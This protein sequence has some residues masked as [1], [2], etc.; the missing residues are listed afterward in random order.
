MKSL[1]KY[2]IF[3]VLFLSMLWVLAASLQACGE[4]EFRAC[5][6][7]QD[8]AISTKTKYCL[9]GVCSDKQ[10]ISGDEGVCYVGPKATAN[11][12]ICRTGRK[13]CLKEGVWSACL[14]QV[15]PR[16]EICDRVDND[17][18]G[19]VD[20]GIDCTCEPGTR[21][22]CYAGPDGTEAK[23]EC[24]YG[25][26]FCLPDNKWG[27]CLDQS[28]PSTE[29]CDKK[30]NDCNGQ[31][32]DGISCD[33]EAG[34][35]RSCYSSKGGCIEQADGSY[36]CEGSCAVGKQ[37]C[38]TDRIWGECV[39]QVTPVEESCDGQDNDCNGLID[40]NVAG[41]GNP[42]S[43]PTAKGIC[44]RGS[45]QCVDGKLS[46]VSLQKPVDEICGNGLD[47][48]CDGQIDETPPCGC[49]SGQSQTCYTETAG[50]KEGADGKWTCQGSCRTGMQFCLDTQV[51]S[52]CLSVQLPSTEV[53]DGIDNDCDGKTDEGLQRSCFGGPQQAVG[54]GECKQGTQTCKAGV[55][56]GCEGEVVPL[57]ETCNGK[58][59]NCDGQVDEICPCQAGQTQACGSTE[60]ECK[61][62]SQ[63][64]SQSGQWGPCQGQ[65]APAQE[66][67]D[68]KDNDCNGKIDDGALG[69]G[70]DC[71]TGQAG[72]CS[73]GK[74]QCQGGKVVCAG[75]SPVTELC[76]E[77][78]NDCDGKID[79]DWSKKGE[80]CNVGQG[81]CERTGT[82]VCRADL[83]DTQCN[84]VPGVPALDICDGKDNDCDGSVDEGCGGCMS[85][86][87]QICGSMVGLCRQGSQTCDQRGLWGPCVGE[88]A[89]QNEICDD[90]DNDCDGKVDENWPSKGFS[91]D[92]G[93]GA[94][95]QTGQVVC[96]TNKSGVLCDAV[97]NPP[98]TEICDGI[99][100]DCDGQIDG[101]T[102]SCEFPAVSIGCVLGAGG[103]W[104]CKG[105][106]RTGEQTCA[107][108][109]WGACSGSVLP[110]NEI[111]GN[112]ID[113]DCNGKVDDCDVAT[114]NLPVFTGPMNVV[115]DLAFSPNHTTIASAHSN[116]SVR[117][118]QTNSGAQLGVLT[119]HTNDVTSVVFLDDSTVI[120]ASKDMTIRY[121]NVIQNKLLSTISVHTGEINDLEIT[122]DKKVLASTSK[123]KTIRLWNAVDGMP[124]RTINVSDEPTRIT[125]AP[126][127]QTLAAVTKQKVLQIWRVSDGMLLQTISTTDDGVDV[128]YRPDGRVI[129]TALVNKEMS[130]WSPLSSTGP[131]QK[132][133][134]ANDAIIS[135]RYSPDGWLAAGLANGEIRIWTPSG[136]LHRTLS[137]HTT[138][139]RTVAW[140]SDSAWLAGTD[141]FGKII[142][143]Y[144]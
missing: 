7:D 37:S 2:M 73:S 74:S 96:N 82:I 44:Q 136:T 23:G 128:G 86:H 125:F 79:E 69:L 45:E 50:C 113:D 123:D 18:D 66:I 47:D 71:S 19:R 130:F 124:L 24:R 8:C 10:C 100:N 137:L 41:A 134:T 60:G 14:E 46:C 59:D 1:P 114:S 38:G 39:A 51:W 30:D 34:S 53:C 99:D 80:T 65:V 12:G 120:S 9:G 52:A 35:T 84:A 107:A 97:A 106:C 115:W 135:L 118:W 91:C 36:R 129:T 68:G 142:V 57:P 32:D 103:V 85:G 15:L 143:W 109:Q 144:R 105:T 131:L 90:Q 133:Y 22:K 72:A 17:C 127:G 5:S 119:G 43:H 89:P 64:C 108:G 116:K 117:L 3:R 29:I 87:T 126:D 112:G 42:C 48:N 95:L 4:P 49:R 141:D 16:A 63:T 11:I 132:L 92:A 111:C 20:E 70:A 33:C 94:C 26:Q 67:C 93:V 81:A 101:I 138:V 21:Q 121:W 139:V 54:V 6:T 88:V 27:N 83:R 56:G 55:W 104:S 110:T 61:Q 75:A 58:D 25:S 40:D 31:I 98:S 122:V 140:S 78:D 76:D 28:G 13:I 77:I 62:G 102:R